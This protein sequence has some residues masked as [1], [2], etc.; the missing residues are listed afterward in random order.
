MC[1][2]GMVGQ[3][4]HQCVRQE[5]IPHRPATLAQGGKARELLVP[6]A[7]EWP[8]WWRA[9][10]CGSPKSL[11]FFFSG[12]FQEMLEAVQSAPAQSP[13]LIVLGYTQQPVSMSWITSYYHLLGIISLKS[14]KQIG[15]KLKLENLSWTKQF[16]KASLFRLSEQAFQIF[17]SENG[18]WLS[19]NK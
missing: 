2:G 14:Y 15:I 7:L 13:V 11:P 16:F 17:K 5:V 8:A 9:R 1:K 19:D 10:K 3:Y 12:R 4:F 6:C 18:K